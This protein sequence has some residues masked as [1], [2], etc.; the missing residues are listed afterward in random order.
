MRRI[1]QIER[2]VFAGAGRRDMDGVL[3]SVY[4]G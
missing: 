1:A 3:R 4:A 2:D